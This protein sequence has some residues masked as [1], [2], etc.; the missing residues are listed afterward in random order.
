VLGGL[1]AVAVTLGVS[2]ALGGPDRV[3]R[4]T[5]DNPTPYPLEVDVGAAGGGA[6]LALGPVASGERHAF[7]SVVD[8]GDRWVVHVT[9]ARSDGGEIVLSRDDLERSDWVITIPDEVGTKLG[10]AGATPRTELG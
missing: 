10:A 3:D 2:W 6:R 5:I 8:Q 1:A 9:S 7:T 4:L